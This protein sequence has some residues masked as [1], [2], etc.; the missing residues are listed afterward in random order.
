MCNLASVYCKDSYEN[1]RDSPGCK[2]SIKKKI[3]LKVQLNTPHL[4]KPI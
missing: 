2:V 4:P 1:P 3:Q